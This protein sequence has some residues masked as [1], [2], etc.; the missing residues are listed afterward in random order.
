[1]KIIS[2][3]ANKVYPKVSVNMLTGT[4]WNMNTWGPSGAP[5]HGFQCITG[6]V[7]NQIPESVSHVGYLAEGTSYAFDTTWHNFGNPNV[8]VEN[9]QGCIA[10]DNFYDFKI[11]FDTTPD[12]NGVTDDTG[13]IHPEAKKNRVILHVS[14]TDNPSN[15]DSYVGLFQK[16]WSC[17]MDSEAFTPITE[18]QYAPGGYP[19]FIQ[20]SNMALD[21]ANNPVDNPA[22]A[23]VQNY[24][25]LWLSCNGDVGDHCIEPGGE[26]IPEMKNCPFAGGTKILGGSGN[27]SWIDLGLH[28]TGTYKLTLTSY[29][30][31]VTGAII[32][33]VVEDEITYQVAET[34]ETCLDPSASNYDPSGWWPKVDHCVYETIAPTNVTKDKKWPKQSDP[35]N[36]K[37][38]D[39]VNNPAAATGPIGTADA[40]TVTSQ[41]TS[42]PAAALSPGGAKEPTPML[43]LGNTSDRIF[44]S[45][46][47]L[48]VK[49]KLEARQLLA[50]GNVAVGPSVAVQS[51]Y[52]GTSKD[53]GDTFLLEDDIL[54]MDL[55]FDG[56]S[57]LASRTPWAR[58]WTAV[59]INSSTDIRNWG[60]END[61]D[62]TRDETKYSY[63]TKSGRVYEYEIN[64]YDR[65]TYV[66][67]NNTATYTQTSPNESIQRSSNSIL[68]EHSVNLLLPEQEKTSK[69]WHQPPAGITSVS[70]ETMGPMGEIRKVSVNF[71]VHNFADFENI[72]Q[73]YFLKPGA[74][75][76]IDYGWSSKELY[77]PETLVYNEY[78]NGQNLETL[79]YGKDGVVTNSAGD[80][81]VFNGY[82]T[83]YSSKYQLNGSVECSLEIVSKN[84]ALLGANYRDWHNRK[85]AMLEMLD[86]K[87]MNF[88]AE[89]YGGEILTEHKSYDPESW[90]EWKNVA[91][92]WAQT[93]LSD[94]DSFHLNN[95]R[96]VLSGV[97]YKTLEKME[98]NEDGDLE[99]VTLEPDSHNLYVSFGFMEDIIFNQELSVS[100]NLAD[101]AESQNFKLIFDSS[102]SFTTYNKNID[103]MHKSTDRKHFTF[104][105]P[106]QWWMTY[107]TIRD[108]VP[109][110]RKSDEAQNRWLQDNMMTALP[111]NSD[112]NTWGA[113]DNADLVE[114]PG[115]KVRPD[116]VDRKPQNSRIPLR[117]IFVSLEVIKTAIKTKDSIRGMLN[118]ILKQI[119]DESQGIINL[120]ISSNKKQQNEISIVD[121]N[122]V[123]AE[124]EN[125]QSYLERLFT[126]SP[127]SKNSIVTNF[128][129]SF[130]MPSD[131]LASMIA[132]QSGV[133]STNIQAMD[134]AVDSVLAKTVID[135]LDSTDTNIGFSYLPESTDFQLKKF[136]ARS[137]EGAETQLGKRYTD[138]EL[139]GGL[140]QQKTNEKLNAVANQYSDPSDDHHDGLVDKATDPTQ[141][142]E[143]NAPKSDYA[144]GHIAAGNEEEDT[145]HYDESAKYPAD[146]NLTKSVE[147]WYASQAKSA[148]F[149]DIVSTPIPVNLTLSTYGTG[150]LNPGDIFRV[151]HL[152][153]RYRELVY[154]QTKNVKHEIS[155]NMWTT[156]LETFMRI[157]PNAKKQSDQ[158]G[159]GK[160]YLSLDALNNNMSFQ[161]E[162]VAYKNN[163]YPNTSIKYQGSDIDLY[164]LS[165]NYPKSVPRD[166]IYRLEPYRHEGYGPAKGYV[167]IFKF[168]PDR[169]IK[170]RNM[171][172]IK[173]TTEQYNIMATNQPDKKMAFYKGVDG[174]CGNGGT[175][176]YGLEWAKYQ[177][178]DQNYKHGSTWGKA[179]IFTL[180]EY[181][182]G[183]SWNANIVKNSFYLLV[184]SK[185]G[186]WIVVPS[187]TTE[188]ILKQITNIFYFF[189][190]PGYGTKKALNHPFHKVNDIEQ[191][192][193]MKWSPGGWCK[194]D[195]G[196]TD[197][198]Y[199]DD[200]YD[201]RGGGTS[202]SYDH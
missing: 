173:P 107:N 111:I 8:P 110:D 181:N 29:E 13:N 54:G 86:T 117:E 55:Q 172:Y 15:P 145:E 30:H 136:I 142:K 185:G 12:G 161:M 186:N 156:T 152:P 10:N 171:G 131:E 154:F 99:W 176:R 123:W 95:R 175:K 5:E 147:K 34:N 178:N 44:G 91:L 66:I 180:L 85:L 189:E 112:E 197:V 144:G 96:A 138:L 166:I 4:R 41:T 128:D 80:M 50:E 60:I 73:R 168:Q 182:V 159:A 14:H 58:L 87:I 122:F 21:Y 64:K 61:K 67:G 133:G 140:N 62:Y 199:K 158:Y 170:L 48:I 125:P 139:F 184:V 90:D 165:F 56:V 84:G 118:Y 121:T 70:S 162:P 135:R 114:S 9:Q 188:K 18:Q 200:I 63:V 113:N 35:K 109:W 6:T 193:G 104:L 26:G 150:L 192:G 88:I 17:E 146:V 76:F 43:P 92:N 20:D 72:Y 164:S 127:Y 115:F 74:Q 81:E 2:P 148:Y 47:P 71:I 132:I 49:R 7:E 190:R 124:R 65:R 28:N 130:D 75:V 103:A 37:N 19:S 101:D 183:I 16:T 93:G 169:N 32:E 149:R 89:Q 40:N 108:K 160:L 77:D 179:H 82:V 201:T 191:P 51:K 78:M 33:E 106:A 157:S 196:W 3:I 31:D 1:M 194:D 98:E 46:I 97:Y 163:W 119:N 120:A 79:L 42:N 59:Q 22:P 198:W 102:N 83:N 141:Y 69:E 57:D 52:R 174:V 68:D 202:R 100:S 39:P 187:N 27:P 143:N 94:S 25:C 151:D 129:I 24:G 126:F 177:I 195:D 153:S 105:Y 11:A 38:T 53:G 23:I 155:Q 116:I 36:D 137:A 167:R 45:D 134:G